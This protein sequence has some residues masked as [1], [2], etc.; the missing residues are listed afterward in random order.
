M[1]A[2]VAVPSLP[3]EWIAQ[4]RP[5][6][7]I[8]LP[9]DR[10]NCGGLLA[11]LTVRSDGIAQGRFLPHFGGFMPVRSVRRHDA[12]DQAFRAIEDDQGF[13]RRSILPADIITQETSPVEFFAALTNIGGGWNYL[14]FT[15]T[16]GGPTETWIAQGDGS[17]VCHTSTAD[18]THSVRQGGPTRL[19]DQVESAYRQWCQIGRPTRERFGL[20]ID[21]GQ[22]TIWLDDPDGPHQWPLPLVL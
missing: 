7:V 14:T 10:R 5:G 22:H 1:L 19:W 8:L 15:P 6:G 12:A 13:T 17:W 4:S 16:N 11:R 2:T 9:L 18:G 20:T 3:G 21:H